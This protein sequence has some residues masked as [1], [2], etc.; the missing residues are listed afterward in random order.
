MQSLVAVLHG[1][2]HLYMNKHRI[3]YK[4]YLLV[5]I[6]TGALFFGGF[7]LNGYING[8]KIDQLKSIQDKISVDLL[9]SETQYSLLSETSCQDAQNFSLSSELSSLAEKLDYGERTIGASNPDIISLRRYY[10]IMEIKDYL[11]NKRL[12]EK[13]DIQS[14]TMLY[15]YAN[16]NCEECAR[17]WESIAALRDSHPDIHV[18]TFEYSSDLSAVQALVSIFKIGNRL[19]AMVVNGKVYNGF[20]PLAD[21]EALFP[22]TPVSVLPVQKPTSR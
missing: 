5:F 2:N 17:Q 19:P 22:E 12:A 14:R 18:Y 21:L 8:K 20:L 15:F 1:D 16:Q 11:L 4:K 10:S 6:I 7:Y 9:S 13:C 3:D